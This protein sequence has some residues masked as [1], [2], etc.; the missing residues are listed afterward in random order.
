MALGNPRL[1]ICRHYGYRMAGWFYLPDLSL[2][3]R[4][5]CPSSACR[6]LAWFSLLPPYSTPIFVLGYQNIQAV[7]T[8]ST[9]LTSIS[10]CGESG[11]IPSFATPQI[12]VAIEY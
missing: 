4:L 11:H 8:H 2:D 1:V 7:I 3:A 12:E 9:S 5:V 6:L 10:Q